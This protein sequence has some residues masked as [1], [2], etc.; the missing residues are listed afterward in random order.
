M[1]ETDWTK[2]NLWDVATLL[3]LEKSLT[4]CF[5]STA[6]SGLTLETTMIRTC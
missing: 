5:W 6:S 4:H 3:S 2:T 1:N